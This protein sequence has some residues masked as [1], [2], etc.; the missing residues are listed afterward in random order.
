MKQTIIVTS[1]TDTKT[2]TQTIMID[3]RSVALCVLKEI[4]FSDAINSI[5]FPAFEAIRKFLPNSHGW[6][7][8][9]EAGEIRQY[10]ITVDVRTGEGQLFGAHLLGWYQG[11]A[12]GLVQLIKGESKGVNVALNASGGE[13]RVDIHPVVNPNLAM[14]IVGAVKGCVMAT[15]S[16]SLS[17]VVVKLPEIEGEGTYIH[18]SMGRCTKSIIDEVHGTIVNVVRLLTEDEE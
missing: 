16:M 6:A 12:Q 8:D 17:T 15:P 1:S 7:T 3:A 2:F 4:N 10:M 14:M 5:R 13:I 11:L 18:I 9:T